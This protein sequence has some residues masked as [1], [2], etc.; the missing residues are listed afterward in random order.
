MSEIKPTEDVT[1]SLIDGRSK[2]AETEF[3]GL[4]QLW[5]FDRRTSDIWKLFRK[6]LLTLLNH[7]L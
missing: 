4:S 3:I 6:D 5:D 7:L 1:A 2:K